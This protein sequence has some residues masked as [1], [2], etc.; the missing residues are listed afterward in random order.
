M[1]EQRNRKRLEDIVVIMEPAS[2]LF[3]EG[4]K[5]RESVGVASLTRRRPKRVQTTG[6]GPGCVSL[7]ML[8]FSFN[9]SGIELEKSGCLGQGKS[10]TVFGVWVARPRADSSGPTSQRTKGGF[11]TSK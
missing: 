2:D 1:N 8:G 4:E 3:K 10:R 11:S 5:A 9:L 7:R 6:T